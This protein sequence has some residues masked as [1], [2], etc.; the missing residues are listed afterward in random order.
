MKMAVCLQPQNQSKAASFGVSLAAKGP[1]AL[2]RLPLWS[3]TRGRDCEGIIGCG[4]LLLPAGE[5]PQGG[6]ALHDPR[7]RE[8]KGAVPCHAGYARWGSLPPSAVLGGTLGE[9]VQSPTAGAM[10][11]SG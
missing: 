9:K 10:A 11:G 5:T 7:T 3:E 1:E 8:C 6:V 2:T 4:E